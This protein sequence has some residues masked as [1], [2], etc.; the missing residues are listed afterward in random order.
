MMV[1]SIPWSLNSQK[2]QD[3]PLKQGLYTPITHIPI[4][5]A[6]ALYEHKPDYVLVLAWNFAEPIMKVHQMYS[7][8]IGKFIL[9]MPVPQIVE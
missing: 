5:S 2:L 3:N 9:P 7:D 6:E 8:N 1:S 4:L